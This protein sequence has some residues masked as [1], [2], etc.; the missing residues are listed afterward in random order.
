MKR[1]LALGIVVAIF[2]SV[3]SAFAAIPKAGGT[4]SKAGATST[5]AGKK[6]TCVKS[7]K[8]LVWNKGVA[9]VTCPPNNKADVQGISAARANALIG[10]N[11]VNAESC[12][13]KLGWGYRV[14]ELE[15]EQ[16]MLTTDY[17]VDR[18]TLYIKSALV[19]KVDVG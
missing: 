2:A 12:A 5:S 16:F 17:R 11:K 8:K 10:K 14:G 9:V 15:G 19:Y 18:V 7:G 1:T 13:K 4:C 6:Y 3:P